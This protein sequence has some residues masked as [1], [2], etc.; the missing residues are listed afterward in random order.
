MFTIVN[1]TAIFLEIY[2]QDPRPS[3]GYEHVYVDVMSMLVWS[4]ILLRIRGST[5]TE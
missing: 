3:H 1:V 4:E 5:F 2:T